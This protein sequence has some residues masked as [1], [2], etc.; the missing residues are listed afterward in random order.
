MGIFV[1]VSKMGREESVIAILAGL[2]S[3][4]H[5]DSSEST[6]HTPMNVAFIRGMASHSLGFSL[7]H[8]WL[9]I[10]SARHVSAETIVQILD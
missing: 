5:H 4:S 8:F 7:L 9:G 1:G 2:S 10:R 6:G 3:G